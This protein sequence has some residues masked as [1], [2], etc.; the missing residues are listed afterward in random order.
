MGYTPKRTPHELRTDPRAIAT[1][2]Y[3]GKTGYLER[4]SVPNERALDTASLDRLRDDQAR[5][6]EARDLEADNRRGFDGRVKVIDQQRAEDAKEREVQD[7]ENFLAPAC[8]AFLQAGGTEADWPAAAEK[9]MEERRME[10]ARQ[11]LTERN[12]YANDPM[13]RAI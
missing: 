5:W 8:E 1:N 12:P 7:R 11:A 2:P 3:I 10:R 4:P 6:D 9:L 13:Y